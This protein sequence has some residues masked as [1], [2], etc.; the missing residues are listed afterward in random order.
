MGTRSTSSLIIVSA[1]S[2]ILMW[3]CGDRSTET[4]GNHRSEDSVATA[5]ANVPAPNPASI[6]TKISTSHIY[7]ENSG[8]MTGYLGAGRSIEIA[9][10]RLLY[11]LE[12]L[13][14][15]QDYYFYNTE[16]HAL[17]RVEN[18]ASFIKTLTPQ[19]IRVGDQSVSD[20]NAILET[21]LAS[22]NSNEL[23]LLVTDGIYSVKAESNADLLGQLQVASEGTFYRF[24]NYLSKH[25]LQTVLIKLTS[26]FKGEYY[27]AQGGI[28]NIDQQRPYYIWLFGSAGKIAKLK[29]QV[30]IEE[31]PGYQNHIVFQA[32]DEWEPAYAIHQTHNKTGTFRPSR[33]AKE[34][35]MAIIEAEP[36][37]RKKEFQFA[38][39]IQLEESKVPVSESYLLNPAN[40]TVSDAKYRVAKVEPAGQVEGLLK[41]HMP[42]FP[43]THFITLA[44]NKYPVGQFELAL[45]NDLP[46][47]IKAAHSANDQNIEGDSQTTFGFNYLVDGIVRAY[48]QQASSTDY[49]K[50]S[51]SVKE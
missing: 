49:F 40:Y 41:V 50:I 33:E 30:P 48:S 5:K 21:V 17:P 22:T 20:L 8:S 31:L 32:N 16:A 4:R 10:S 47:W 42:D 1:A 45:R 14:N 9:L 2:L 27:P 24:K 51:L 29:E 44:T 25:N 38:V 35:G 15:K 6:P 34:K 7:F 37:R 28:K 26:Q 39:G 36:D 3:S 46:S 13:S 43:V 18:T 23:S 19:G 12:D 11:S